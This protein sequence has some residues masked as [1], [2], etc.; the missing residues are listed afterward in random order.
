MAEIDITEQDS[1]QL[2][3]EIETERLDPAIPEVGGAASLVAVDQG[4]DPVDAY[5]KATES[6]D[7]G[8]MLNTFESSVT[9]DRTAM[10]DSFVGINTPEVIQKDAEDFTNDMSGVN[11][12]LGPLVQQIKSMPSS[13]GMSD[14][15]VKEIASVTMQRQALAQFQPE[16]VVEGFGDFAG[17][18]VPKRH[19]ATVREISSKLGF[20]STVSQ[21][22]GILFDP[23]DE[24]D[25]MRNIG[26]SLEGEEKAEYIKAV[27]EAVDSSSDN[28][29]IKSRIMDA[30]FGGGTT[31][32]ESGF[33]MLDLAFTTQLFSATVKTGTNLYKTGSALNISRKMKAA[34][35]AAEII[36]K[37]S[38]DPAA[39]KALGVTKADIGDALNPLINGESAKVLEGA[40]EDL[41][42]EIVHMIALQDARFASVQGLSRE[43]VLDKETAAQVMRAAE[44]EQMKKP[45]VSSAKITSSDETGV[46]LE[47]F[48]QRFDEVGKPIT[49]ASGK[50]FVGRE[51]KQVDFKLNDQ[52]KIEVL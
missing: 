28:N 10:M 5:V 20:T 27:T 48:E 26:I 19:A 17:V 7:M 30:I 18:L 14:A 16:G 4:N 15:Q 50:P 22:L 8:E 43:G 21:D 37:A 31:A 35:T 9:E 25:Q 3:I 36:V 12:I 40:S 45:G 23:S 41:T 13:V 47:W 52:G 32:F 34:D 38:G 44:I 49:S 33:E 24:L 39:A 46:K 51:T 2:S 1:E 11:G 42:A 29:F 6:G